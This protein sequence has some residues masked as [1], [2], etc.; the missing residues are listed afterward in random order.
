MQSCFSIGNIKFPGSRYILS[1][2]YRSEN[3]KQHMMLFSSTCECKYFEDTFV[4]KFNIS[5]DGICVER[6]ERL[7]VANIFQ[8]KIMFPIKPNLFHLPDKLFYM[9]I[10]TDSTNTNLFDSMVRN[11]INFM[12]IEDFETKGGMVC[13]K[14]LEVQ[15]DETDFDPQD[16][17]E[18][19]IRSLDTIY[20]E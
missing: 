13:L 12:I 3:L 4:S 10:N 14:G 20:L 6:E 19:N 15:L 9:D 18:K 8:T 1:S 16:F 17:H 7:D 11:H 5:N 2:R